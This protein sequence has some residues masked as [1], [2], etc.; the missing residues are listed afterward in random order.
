MAL[1]FKSFLKS[2]IFKN[3]IVHHGTLLLKDPFKWFTRDE[4]KIIDVSTAF[5]FNY[6]LLLLN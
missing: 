1:L 5:L 4:K 3:I 2:D 6:I